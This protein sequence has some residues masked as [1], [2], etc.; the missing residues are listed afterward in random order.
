MPISTFIAIAN[1]TGWLFLCCILLLTDLF[2]D[3]FAA[4]LC[5]VI[6]PAPVLLIGSYGW[7]PASIGCFCNLY[8]SGRVTTLLLQPITAI[9][10]A[11]ADAAASAALSPQFH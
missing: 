9:A 7:L 11:I 1:V 2:L 3:L 8:F 10:A 5:L 6:L 4:F